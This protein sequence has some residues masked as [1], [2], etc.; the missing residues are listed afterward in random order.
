VQIVGGNKDVAEQVSTGKLDI[1]LTDTDDAVVFQAQGYKIAIIYLDRDA[2]SNDLG[3]LFIPNSLGIVKDCRHPE[4]ARK[5]IDH[6]LS[7]G[8]EGRLAEGE[9]AQIPLGSK[10][11]AK[12]RVETP[13]TVKAMPVDFA[14]A[15]KK[16]DV[17]HEFLRKTFA[18][19]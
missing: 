7:A 10:V 1:G 18:V 16:W 12:V 6:L 4:A 5:L 3:T 17:A 19:Q 14:A 13:A 2:E 9:S 15:A 8:T 11:T